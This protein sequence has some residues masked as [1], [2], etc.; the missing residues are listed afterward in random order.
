MTRLWTFQSK[1]ILAGIEA[2]GLHTASWE[3]ASESF[4]PAYRWMAKCLGEFVNHALN[5]PPV[6]CWHS[7]QSIGMAPTVDTARSLLSDYDIERGMV[8]IELEVPPA[9]LLASSYHE[10]NE[11]L[12]R[13]IE[14]G[15][16]PTEREWR[17]MF[18]VPPVKHRGDDIQA[19][20]PHIECDWVIAS[21]PL[22][23]AGRD[24]T[25][26]V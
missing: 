24:K 15:S 9:S 16:A 20:I 14:C 22:V 2:N 1:A 7:C 18:D 3:T 19:V 23:I 25:D 21:R 4:R 6:W 8:V 13:T 12:D 10:W 5:A 17:S 26:A 11:F